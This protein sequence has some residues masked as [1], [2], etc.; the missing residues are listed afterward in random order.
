MSSID[1][2]DSTRIEPVERVRPPVRRERREQ[3]RDERDE[4]HEP[5]HD[6]DA[7]EPAGSVHVDIRI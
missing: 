2:I 3:P 5:P 7:G 6:E 4:A 1:R